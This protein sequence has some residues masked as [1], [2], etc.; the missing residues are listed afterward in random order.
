V[1][2]SV[3]WVGA[4]R[5]VLAGDLSGTIALD[6]LRDIPHLYALGPVEAL[7]GEV[8]IFDGQPSVSR[9]ADHAIAID[10]SFRYRAC[11]LVYASVAEW[12]TVPMP[13]PVRGERD[14]E[15]RVLEAARR[16][17][18]DIDQPFPF[19]IDGRADRLT[20][21]VLDKRD[22]L[23]HT[24]ELHERAKVRFAFA[25]EPVEIVGFFS[26]RHRGI[27]T[28]RDAN[29]HMHVRTRDGRASGHLDHIELAAGGVLRLPRKGETS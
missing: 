27:F 29:L 26:D 25:G 7:L 23:P 18:V 20:L 22:G 24:P 13:A 15:A 10:A 2:A 8:S 19:L 28:P 16:H 12:T 6:A 14:L 9:V 11:F 3:R 21:H 1:T 17:G 4:Q 5:D